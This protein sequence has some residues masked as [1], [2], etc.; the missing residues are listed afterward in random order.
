MEGE[1]RP[2]VM[3]IS[4]PSQRWR[5]LTELGRD[6]IV[7]VTPRTRS[8]KM[9]ETGDRGHSEA[10]EQERSLSTQGPELCLSSSSGL[11][12]HRN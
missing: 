8:Q 7:P 4:T 6:S 3:V 10:W 1:A 5:Q 2:W 12:H 9:E 11:E